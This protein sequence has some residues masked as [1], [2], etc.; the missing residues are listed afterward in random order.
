MS[1]L[2]ARPQS[3]LK[4]RPTSKNRRSPTNRSTI[5]PI[6]E[7]PSRATGAATSMKDPRLAAVASI[8]DKK[9]ITVD[10]GHIPVIS[11]GQSGPNTTGQKEK[12]GISMGEM[13][14]RVVMQGSQQAPIK[15]KMM[16]VKLKSNQI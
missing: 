16:T 9:K 4:V 3:G 13:T 14:K 5:Q 2:K 11:S 15:P 7:T 8:L 10:K 6:M 12:Q 1:T